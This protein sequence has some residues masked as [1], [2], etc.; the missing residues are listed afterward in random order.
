MS[1]DIIK[2]SLAFPIT[3][4]AFVGAGYFDIIDL[5][6]K[7]EL[8]VTSK[9]VYNGTLLNGMG[10]MCK[11]YSY[12]PDIYKSSAILDLEYTLSHMDLTLRLLGLYNDG[13]N[14][15]T[16]KEDIKYQIDNL[17]AISTEVDVAILLD[18]YVNIYNLLEDYS[19]LIKD[20]HNTK[21][22]LA[23]RD[24]YYKKIVNV[25][26]TNAIKYS[27]TLEAIESLKA[28][29]IH[30][31][32]VESVK[33]A[34]AARMAILNKSSV[35]LSNT[36][37]TKACNEVA[38]NTMILND[39]RMYHKPELVRIADKIVNDL[40]YLNNVTYIEATKKYNEI[41][42]SI[43]AFDKI[44]NKLKREENKVHKALGLKDSTL[45]EIARLHASFAE[46][47][48]RL[49]IVITVEGAST[50]QYKKTVAAIQTNLYNITLEMDKH[51]NAFTDIAKYRPDIIDSIYN[52]Q[53]SVTNNLLFKDMSEYNIDL[54]AINMNND[55]I[56]PQITKVL[57]HNINS[58]QTFYQY[59]YINRPRVIDENASLNIESLLR[60]KEGS[61]RLYRKISTMYK[62][63]DNN[64]DYKKTYAVRVA[65]LNDIKIA[66]SNLTYKLQLTREASAAPTELSLTGKSE[67]KDE[68][69]QILTS[70][71]VLFNGLPNMLKFVY[72]IF[73]LI[74]IVINIDEF[75]TSL[76]KISSLV[77]ISDNDSSVQKV[78]TYEN[79]I[80]KMRD[81]IKGLENS[82]Y[83]LEYAVGNDIPI[84][85]LRAQ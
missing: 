53:Y 45:G 52:I 73:G 13:I 57:M 22:R 42:A 37:I 23:G 4:V 5:A 59:A 8:P 30:L 26:V 6:N 63:L 25:K 16:I 60:S 12:L 78:A 61:K 50:E 32:D 71:H 70:T 65:C 49:H 1:N 55:V 81:M 64:I 68:L 39:S 10:P 62:D 38:N 44:Y 3:N 58:M 19:D 31:Y 47:R 20:P 33:T 29:T 84:N 82:I 7:E 34:L 17:N 15:A 54:N 27:G 41:C 56:G 46:L 72:Q 35:K 43:K 83:M 80:D 11:L 40:R 36:E 18:C 76:R 28:N 69:T 75:N 14:A 51:T 2:N 77:K 74:D 66:V 21:V 9:F 85:L 79:Y 24:I 48:R 67:L